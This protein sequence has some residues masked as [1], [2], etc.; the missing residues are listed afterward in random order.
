MKGLKLSKT[1]WLLLSLGVFIVVL[2]SLG[3]T[4][5][6]QLQDQARM[7]EE[8]TS[9]GTELNNLKVSQL[10]TQLE[11]LQEKVGAGEAQLVEAREK[12]RQGI[13]S[14]DVTDRFFLIAGDCNVAVT[15]L[16]TS[17][18]KEKILEDIACSMISL[19]ASV[20]GD[21]ADLIDFVV[22]LNHGY[23][24]GYVESAQITIP[25]ASDESEPTVSLEMFVYSYEG[26]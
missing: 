12:L 7:S 2:A 8:L 23:A 13:E 20:T 15:N 19:S 5:S 11:K 17:A 24:N 26:S 25:E 16:T 9:S 4:R 18:I 21:T 22:S 10:Q 6:R 3:M 1:S 14:A